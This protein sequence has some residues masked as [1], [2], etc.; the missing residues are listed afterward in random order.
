MGSIP[1]NEL[2]DETTRTI[3]RPDVV[4]VVFYSQQA[5]IIRVNLWQ[6]FFSDI[7]K[8]TGSVQV[9]HIGNGLYLCVLSG[10]EDR[11][12]EIIWGFIDL[13]EFK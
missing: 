12:V 8:G 13:E 2:V 11:T 1:R 5:V 9:E 10:S 3:S 4:D 6:D 7:N